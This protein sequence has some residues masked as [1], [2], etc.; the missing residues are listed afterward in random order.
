MWVGRVWELR[1]LLM[2]LNNDKIEAICSDSD[3][4]SEFKK[5]ELKAKLKDR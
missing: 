5:R 3:Q 4:L 1:A 2:H